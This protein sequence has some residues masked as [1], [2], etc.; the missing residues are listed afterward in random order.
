MCKKIV[1]LDFMVPK[2]MLGSTHPRS[3]EHGKQHLC[4]AELASC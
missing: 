1:F 2:F 3:S 4:S